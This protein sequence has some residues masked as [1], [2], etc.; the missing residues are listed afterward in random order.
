MNRFISFVLMIVFIFQIVF[1]TFAVVMTV[2]SF[3][4]ESLRH[5][6]KVSYLSSATNFPSDVTRTAAGT[7]LYAH[8]EGDIK[9]LLGKS[10]VEGEGWSNFGGKSKDL[11]GHLVKTASRETTET[12]FGIYAF[13]DRLLKDNFSH[14][15]YNTA[16]KNLYR[17][18]FVPVKYVAASTFKEKLKSAKEESQKK[19]TDFEWISLK[20]ICAVVQENKTLTGALEDIR[21]KNL[22]EKKDSET[23]P[24]E[25]KLFEPL[26]K[27][28]SSVFVSKKL[29]DLLKVKEHSEGKNLRKGLFKERHTISLEEF[30]PRDVQT[31][32]V[33]WE[34]VS[35]K[36]SQEAVNFLNPQTRT[37]HVNLKNAESEHLYTE[38]V[39]SHPDQEK[40]RVI[41]SLIAKT[42]MNLEFKN[43]MKER[44]EKKEASVSSKSALQ[45]E[46]SSRENFPSKKY[47]ASEAHLRMCLGEQ[48][49][50]GETQETHKQNITALIKKYGMGSEVNQEGDIT[51]EAY[52]RL[53]FILEEE[54][55]ITFDE[56]LQGRPFGY[57]ALNHGCRQEMMTLYRAYSA[58]EDVFSMCPQ[59]EFST[60]RAPFSYMR[61]YDKIT[62][63]L[64]AYHQDHRVFYKALYKKF[65]EES[66]D[67]SQIERSLEYQEWKEEKQKEIH[68]IWQETL[69]LKN[70][71]ENSHLMLWLNASLMAGGDTANI[72]SSSFAFFLASV[73]VKGHYDRINFSGDRRLF[74]QAMALRGMDASYEHFKALFAQYITPLAPEGKFNGGLLQVFVNT[75]W[76]DL[77]SMTL[78]SGEPHAEGGGV[79]YDHP[80]RQETGVPRVSRMLERLHGEAEKEYVTPE[81]R[82]PNSRW[83]PKK[84]LISEVCFL[85]H[86]LITHTIPSSK[87]KEE[88]LSVDLNDHEANTV[89]ESNY[90]NLSFPPLH[91][92]GYFR[93]P[94]REEQKVNFEAS[95]YEISGALI[96]DWLY[97]GGN[98]FEESA[99]RYSAIHNFY[100]QIYE[101]FTKA[102]PLQKNSEKVLQEALLHVS[103]LG[104][105]EDLKS[106]LKGYEKDIITSKIDFKGCFNIFLVKGKWDMFEHLYGVLNSRQIIPEFFGPENQ[107]EFAGEIARS[108]LFSE[109]AEKFFGEHI[110]F[111]AFSPEFKKSL[112]FH[113]SGHDDSPEVQRLYRF[114]KDRC[115]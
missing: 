12:S 43:R 49:V 2:S 7:L 4:D 52:D 60:L 89:Y 44:A 10:T 18:Y 108:S 5:F 88:G 23:T 87:K 3:D 46:S 76:C 77:Y 9:I 15:L 96:A 74:Q 86:P 64:E 48:Y 25:E 42:L 84:G 27:M 100:H 20:D 59:G 71:Q 69:P 30:N 93:Y 16:E 79:P 103:R 114:I 47:T 106:F 34:E 105:I 101:D 109:T 82:N 45:G 57:E 95:L 104:G 17:L 94:L 102:R 35:P 72:T 40:N 13:H 28:L 75:A 83:F 54:R 81:D 99:H 115:Q 112:L 31:T 67:P 113:A 51:E 19:Y 33:K 41:E 58:M 24:T 39:T 37:R 90:E 26:K 110:D 38:D 70:S 32:T 55:R 66:K 68:R 61:Q 111:T 11:D 73:S 78:W 92:K 98:P 80:F 97:E 107:K 63:I 56:R 8:H 53:S 1:P 65:R 85:L 62:N 22:L 6:E 91:T 50:F 14:D 29:E 21:K 36:I